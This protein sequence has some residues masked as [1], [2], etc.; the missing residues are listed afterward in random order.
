M[1][2]VGAN[3]GQLHFFDAGIYN[4]TKK[5]F[6]LGSGYELFSIMP[7]TAMPI[8]REVVEKED[9]AYSMD[10][11]VRIWDVFIDPD[12]NGTPSSTQREWRTIVVAP[13]RKAGLFLSGDRAEVV[14]GSGENVLGSIIAVDVT[15]PD[16]L[17]PTDYTPQV[18]PTTKIDQQIP[19]CIRMPSSCSGK[20]P[21]VLWE[22]SD[23][24]YVP[25]KG[26]V[27]YYDE[28]KNGARDMADPWSTPVI[29]RVKIIRSGSTFDPNEPNFVAIFGGGIDPESIYT[30]EGSLTVNKNP[31]AG[32]F[33]YIVDIET[34]KILYKREVD[35]M[36][37]D[38][39]AIDTDDD[40]F[41]DYIY[42]G[43]TAGYVYKIDVT[44]PVTLK[45]INIYTLSGATV[46]EKRVVDPSWDPFVIFKASEE[47]SKPIFFRPLLT[48]VPSKGAYAVTVGTGD[49]NNLWYN[50]GENTTPVTQGIYTF[51]DDGLDGSTVIIG[52]KLPEELSKFLVDNPPKLLIGPDK[53][54]KITLEV[55]D[56]KY[57]ER[58]TAPPITVGG[59]VLVLGTFIPQPGEN[60]NACGVAGIGKLYLVDALSG[61][62]ITQIKAA[63]DVK[64]NKYV[65]TPDGAP[66]LAPIT[67]LSSTGK[68]T[69]ASLI[70]QSKWDDIV[71]A[72]KRNY[73]ARA[74]TGN[75][76]ISVQLRT[77]SDKLFEAL[78]IPIGVIIS[79]WKGL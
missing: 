27:S 42:F 43:T 7:R 4:K 56:N 51:L 63:S 68:S 22:F 57:M 6:T 21:R 41:V 46:S 78:R 11:E 59:G 29:S 17:N 53:G 48:Y 77:A 72:I 71:A 20:F 44:K 14:K 28:D 45:P 31:K 32:N 74:K 73:P 1:L 61:T 54:W 10:G 50:G 64:S 79:N 2:V 66:P 23:S 62:A 30:T 16:P 33:V 55:R 76:Y 65:E 12:H 60:T 39:T 52:D 49:R 25:G 58:L 24:V 35:G 26:E 8:L 15:Y 9:H 37:A 75:Y 36:V 18:D 70:D 47:F 5:E 69:T 13:M 34:G 67:S 38:V 40:T 19:R 3:D